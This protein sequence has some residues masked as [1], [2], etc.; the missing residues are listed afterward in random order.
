MKFKVGDK[1]RVRSDLVIGKKYGGQGCKEKLTFLEAMRLKAGQIL[2]VARH[3]AAG[4]YM[5]TET[6]YYFSEDMLEPA[7]KDHRKIVITQDGVVTK[8]R[9][10]NGDTVIKETSA[11]CHPDDE[12]DFEIGAS[13]AFERLGL[14]PTKTSQT[15]QYY[16]GKVVCITSSV[17]PGGFSQGRIYEIVSGRIVDDGGSLYEEYVDVEQLND[18]MS[19]KFIEL[20]E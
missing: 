16:S 3:S 13:L 5:M 12:F 19:A 14:K 10:Y 20:I 1:V 7:S 9:L 11:K 15:P 18:D 6:G 8:A 4:N 17:L 2:T